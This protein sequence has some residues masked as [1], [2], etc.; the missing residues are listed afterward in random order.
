MPPNLR[1]LPPKRSIAGYYGTCTDFPY[2][3]Y[4]YRYFE[5]WYSRGTSSSEYCSTR[6]VSRLE[7]SRPNVAEPVVAPH[8]ADLRQ[9]LS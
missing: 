2:F 6:T 3:E 5:Y 4:R 9:A 7:R 1:T 8:R